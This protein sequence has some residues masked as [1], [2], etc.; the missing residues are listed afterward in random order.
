MHLRS[1]VFC[2]AIVIVAFVAGAGCRAAEAQMGARLRDER[3][4]SQVVRMGRGRDQAAHQRQVRHRGVSRQ[5]LGKET[6]IN[7]AMTLGTVDMIIS[8]LSFAARNAAAGHRLLSVHLPRRRPPDRIVEEPGVQ[9][10]GRCVPGEDRHPDHGLHVLR[11]PAYDVEKP[12]TDCAGMKGLKIRVPDVPV[13]MATPKAAARTRRRLHSPR[14]TS[15]CRTARLTRR[16]TR[17]RRSRRRSSTRCRR[18]S[19]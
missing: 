11:R 9:G 15:R 10:N 17:S 18:R 4:V 16:R 8:G 2:A 3:A 7:Q 14:S 6:D 12:F 1:D 13:Y 19:C 5:H